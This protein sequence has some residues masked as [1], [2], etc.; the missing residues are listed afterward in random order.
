LF[1]DPIFHR[2][3][4]IALVPFQRQNVVTAAADADYDIVRR[5]A[6]RV[7]GPGALTRPRGELQCQ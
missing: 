2:F 7:F 6:E 5:L 4:K 1:R 3:V